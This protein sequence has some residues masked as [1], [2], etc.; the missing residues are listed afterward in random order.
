[1]NMIADLIATLV[2]CM[3]CP[4]AAAEVVNEAQRPEDVNAKEVL[5]G[6]SIFL[7]KKALRTI[8]KVLHMRSWLK[9]CCLFALLRR[10]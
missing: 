10:L 2:A 8:L 5:R 9:R 3:C 7:L 6:G 1:M 4:A